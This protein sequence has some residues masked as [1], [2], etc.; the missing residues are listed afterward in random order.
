[1]STSSSQIED[2]FWRWNVS[3]L[4]SSGCQRQNTRRHCQLSRANLGGL[5]FTNPC[6]AYFPLFT[7]C[8][9]QIMSSE[10]P[11][12]P[13]HLLHTSYRNRVIWALSNF[14]QSHTH[15]HYPLVCCSWCPDICLCLKLLL[16]GRIARKLAICTVRWIGNQRVGD[17]AA[18]IGPFLGS[19]IAK[20]AHWGLNGI[21]QTG[22]NTDCAS[23]C[24]IIVQWRSQRSCFLMDFR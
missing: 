7:W 20:W 2:F 14:Q 3:S 17:G 15:L 11:A 24:E 1:M 10:T 22:I 16:P 18:C 4:F 9:R 19:L 5:A 21:S 6:L 12:Q 13:V 23:Y 8:Y